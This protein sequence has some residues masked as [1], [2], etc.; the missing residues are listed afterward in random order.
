MN[1]G[2]FVSLSFLLVVGSVAEVNVARKQQ[3]INRLLFKVTEPLRAYYT[4]LKD[5][6]LHFQPTGIGAQ[7]NQDYV[8]GK[9][10]KR[11]AWFSLF[12]PNH[13]REAITLVQ[14]MLEAEDF[15]H[16]MKIAAFFRERLNE[17]VFVYALYVA[18]THSDFTKGV[19]L[20]PLYEIT[21]HMFTNA[22]VI[23]KA[24]TAK[25][26]QFPAR[27]KMEFTGSKKN[28]EMRVAYFGEDVGIN[29]HHVHWHMDFPFW[30]TGYEMDRKGELFFWMHHQLTARYD[31]ERLSNYL[32]MVEELYWNRP[33]KEGFA[34]HTMY[35]FGGEFPSRPDKK[36]FEDV[37]GFAQVRDLLEL[38][39]RIRDAIDHNYVVDKGGKPIYINNTSG[40]DVLGAIIESSESSPNFELYG[41]LHNTAHILLGRQADPQGKFNMPPGV[42]E[43]F[44]TATRDPSFF[45]LHKYMDS[46]FKLHKDKLSP[47]TKEDIEYKNADIR[48]VRISGQLTTF[49]E[50]FEFDL[51]N[52]L[53]DAETI[54]DVPVSTYINRLNHKP[55]TYKIDVEADH[56]DVTTIRIFLC[57]KYDNNE[58]ELSMDEYRWMCIEMDKFWTKLTAGKNRVVRHSSDSSVTIPD[59]L[60]FQELIRE[61]NTAIDQN[62]E[63]MHVETRA[64]GHPDR[65]LLPRGN[66]EGMEFL[67]LV[68]LTSGKD[69]VL[70]NPTEDDFGSSHGYCGAKGQRYPD[71]RPMGFPLDRRIPDERVF[72]VKNVHV[73]PVKVFLNSMPMPSEFCPQGWLLCPD[74]TC[75]TYRQRCDGVRHCKNA[76][77]EQMCMMCGFGMLSCDDKCIADTKVCDGVVDCPISGEDEADCDEDEAPEDCGDFYFPCNNGKCLLEFY[78][79]DS[80]PDCLEGEDERNCDSCQ[81]G[82][83]L[84]GDRCVA[85]HI[86]C[87]GKVDCPGGSDETDCKTCKQ[88]F[89]QCPSDN[90]CISNK[91][92][93]DGKPDCRRGEDED[94]CDSCPQEH[95]LCPNSTLC[96]YKEFWCDG[97]PQCPGGEDESECDFC[98]DDA[99]HCTSSQECVADSLRCDGTP[100]CQMAEDEVGC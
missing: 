78:R 40:I 29:S 15:E 80:V 45:S 100:N 27:F 20:P 6:A 90:T 72:K 99:F 9:T 73:S 53:D 56:D 43:H 70:T 24:Y 39:H 12:Q 23:Q 58:V 77:D 86:R 95:H 13:R 88:G 54:Y 33:I 71:K 21:P 26:T 92:R 47:Y 91:L 57:P 42:M 85:P 4:D 3:I 48:N 2:V 94:D 98:Y 89:T 46:I 44:E 61:A 36:V 93:C 22:E 28:P 84:C 55:F 67:L 18:V 63:F 14:A 69:A 10:H 37:E 31:A 11:K 96:L 79:C 17:G 1:W 8:E 62:R 30:W 50:G 25:M 83:M 60:S 19:I 51:M 5:A 34:P 82:L 7:L 35:R 65:L 81:E 66:P 75:Y 87:D 41:S 49:F 74:F 32:P 97:D 16:F 64:C 59:R 76:T 52:A 38:E 68:A